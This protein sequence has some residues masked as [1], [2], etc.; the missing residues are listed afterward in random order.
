MYAVQETKSNGCSHTIAFCNSR[1]DAEI[2]I[3]KIENPQL[4]IHIRFFLNTNR[5]TMHKLLNTARGHRS[6]L[7]A[8][9]IIRSEMQKQRS[10]LRIVEAQD[11]VGE[12]VV[13]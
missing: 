6:Q 12:Y 2:L 5:I 9:D 13:W 3:Q 10:A 4:P 11:T 7:S 1:K 8:A